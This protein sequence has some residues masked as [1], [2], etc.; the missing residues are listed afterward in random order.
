MIRYRVKIEAFDEYK[1]AVFV[2][3]DREVKEVMN[4]SSQKIVMPFEVS[5][6]YF[7]FSP[8][9]EHVIFLIKFCH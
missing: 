4:M 5:R 3:R 6:V 7:V 9:M 2:L 1:S 8:D